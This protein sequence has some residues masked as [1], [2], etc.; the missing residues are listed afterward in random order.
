MTYISITGLKPKGLLSF[1]KFWRLAIP[2]FEQARKAKGNQHC[3]V[4]RVKGY[5]CTIT[6]WES[7]EH[8]LNFMR[9]GIHVKAMKVFH[10][11]ATGKTYGFESDKI[12]SW[13]EAFAL[14]QEK[15]R[16]HG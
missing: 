16:D 8:M 13:P 15:G 5:Q 11:I 3:V 12:P 9:S 7:R 1:I 2:S 6:V 14:L 10:K 4:K